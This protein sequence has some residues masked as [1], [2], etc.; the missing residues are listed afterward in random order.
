MSTWTFQSPVPSD[1]EVSQ[2]IPP[3]PIA[4]IAAAA[5]IETSELLPHG[6]AKAKVSLSVR[7]RLS[8]APDGNYVVVAGINPTPLGEGKS[9]TT[10]GVCQALGAILKKRVITCIRQPSQGTVSIGAHPPPPLPIKP[11]PF[12]LPSHTSL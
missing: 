6:H 10:V 8:A 3:L 7:D 9:T 1:I 5:G 2:S 4:D 11:H 12:T